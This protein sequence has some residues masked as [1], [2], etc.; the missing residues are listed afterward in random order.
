MSPGGPGNGGRLP[1]EGGR[2]RAE[3]NKARATAS[4]HR[5]KAV[6]P[7]EAQ[8]VVPDVRLSPTPAQTPLHPNIPTPPHP[9]PTRATPPRDLISCS[10]CVFSQSPLK[11]QTTCPLPS[12]LFMSRAFTLPTRP[13]FETRWPGA[14]R[15]VPQREHRRRPGPLAFLIL[16]KQTVN[17]LQCSFRSAPS[18]P[19][20]W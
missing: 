12:A 11:R 5:I 4:P 2:T 13:Q 17:R 1:T 18:A 20:G 14:E 3:G 10:L 7:T 16:R 6:A 15:K 19:C 9:T 8:A